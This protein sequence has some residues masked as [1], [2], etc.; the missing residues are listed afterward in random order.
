MKPDASKRLKR[1]VFQRLF[2]KCATMEPVDKSCWSYTDGRLVI[3]LARLPELYS[4][5]SAVRLEGADLPERVLLVHGDDGNYYAFKNCCTHGGRRLDAVPGAGTIQCCSVGKS[6]FDYSGRLL[7]GSAKGDVAA[8][9]VQV[10]G[11]TV[12]VNGL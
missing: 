11:E 2:G 7:A 5:G 9:A 8:F 10:E 6:T 4:K 3:D 12:V 1:N